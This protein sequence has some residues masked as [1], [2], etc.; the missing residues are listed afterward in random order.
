MKGKKTGGRQKGTPNKIGRDVRDV[1][2][3]LGGMD[4]EAYAEQLHSIAT[5]PHGDV[6]ARLKALAIIVPY[7]WGRPKEQVELTGEVRLPVR[8]VHEYQRA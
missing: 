8:V 6:H 5:A 2:R 3:Q 7:V 4:G 1:F